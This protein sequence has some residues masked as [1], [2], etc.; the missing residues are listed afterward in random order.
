ML[1]ILRNDVDKAIDESIKQNT[2]NLITV[3][4]VQHSFNLPF[5]KKE[6]LEGFEKEFKKKSLPHWEAKTYHNQEGYD[7]WLQLNCDSNILGKLAD[8]CTYISLCFCI[9]D[10][11]IFFE[12]YSSP[13]PQ[14]E[15]EEQLTIFYQRLR[16]CFENRGIHDK[17]D[18][19]HTFFRVDC[20]FPLN[21]EHC[22]HFA[23]LA[24]EAGVCKNIGSNWPVTPTTFMNQIITRCKQI[25]TILADYNKL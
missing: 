14:Y 20:E 7:G 4:Y 16:D 6:I 1:N 23:A 25:E 9:R 22:E 11:K 12:Y 24:L 19:A 17:F 2:D 18:D 5:I 21:M 8:I 3:L 13:T 15:N 10:G